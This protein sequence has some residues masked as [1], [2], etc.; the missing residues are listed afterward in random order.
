MRLL[1]NYGEATKENNPDITYDNALDLVKKAFSDTIEEQ[2]EITVEDEVQEKESVEKYGGFYV[3]R[4]EAGEDGTIKKGNNP[5][6]AITF[7]QAKEKSESMYN[8]DT[9]GVESRLTD[10][11]SRNAIGTF[12]EQTGAV[13]EWEMYFGYWGIK[14]DGI[15]DSTT[16]WQ[17]T[18]NYPRNNMY[19]LVGNIDEISTAKDTTNQKYLAFGGSYES[20]FS[21]KFYVPNSITEENNTGVGYRPVL[22]IK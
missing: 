11:A 2:N 19:D 13:D 1:K 16:T 4:Y 14:K 20:V 17:K 18:G 21:L 8:S 12:L 22:Y 10:T 7:A 3:A 6:R 9:Y 15:Q 5:A